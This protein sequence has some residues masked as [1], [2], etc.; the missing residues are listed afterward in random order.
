M[1]ENKFQIIFSILSA[2]I[3]MLMICVITFLV[4]RIYFK[5]KNKLLEERQLLKANYDQMLLLAQLEIQ[6]QTLNQIGDEIHDNIG[7]VLS[8][9]RI[10]LNTLGAVSDED[11][12]NVTDEL[13]G[14]AISDLRALS[15]NLNSNFIRSTGLINS[16]QMLL[17]YI[18]KTAQYTTELILT[19]EPW[20]VPDDTS[21]ILFRIL[22]E[23][24]NNSLKHANARHIKIELTHSGAKKR[25]IIVDDGV[26]FELLDSEKKGI[27][28]QNIYKRA[29]MI[30][31]DIDIKSEKD[32]G[33]QVTINF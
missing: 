13:L 11:K 17:S 3:F 32:K 31:A 21:I 23:V 26:G 27:G 18:D 2:S 29:Q 9:V 15:H 24:T 4:F 1:P 16:I 30:G 19:D 25:M 7:Q 6:E 22:Q 14:K 8:L 10:N 20:E 5:R 28:L 33:T 12:L